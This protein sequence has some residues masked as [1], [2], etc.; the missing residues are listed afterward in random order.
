M[1]RQTGIALLMILIAGCVERTITITTEPKGSL[2]YLNDKEVGRTPV[3][4]PFQWYGDYDVVIRKDG[5]ET[6][7]THTKIDPPWYQ[8]IPLDFFS[9]ILWPGVIHDDHYV[10]FEMK[11]SEP[12]NLAELEQRAKDIRTRAGT[13]GLTQLPPA[14]Q[15]PATQPAAQA[16]SKATEA[17]K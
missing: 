14:N 3:T 8:F 16:P 13:Q 9:E 15:T 11:K 1:F 6:L 2:V 4:V 10:D 17:K 12:V 7:K 5:Y